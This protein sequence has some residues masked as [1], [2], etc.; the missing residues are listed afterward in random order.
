MFIELVVVVLILSQIF[1]E[2]HAL[3]HQVLADHLE[4][5]ALLHHLTGNVEGQVFGVN[6]TPHKVQ[7]LRDDVLT[8][9]HD[10]DSAHVQLDVVLLLLVLKQ[11]EGSTLGD[12][13]QSTE[14]QLPLHREVLHTH[15]ICKSG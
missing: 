1:D 9:V 2:L 11:V 8:V 10:E 14:L 13:E 3:L 4:D 12:E 15:N 6:H 7:V 5:L